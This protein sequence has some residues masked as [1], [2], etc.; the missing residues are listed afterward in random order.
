MQRL[1]QMR[2]LPPRGTG[3]LLGR[4][5]ARRFGNPRTYG[6]RLARHPGVQMLQTRKLNVKTL[7]D[8]MAFS[9]SPFVVAVPSGI[10]TGIRVHDNA[11][12]LDFDWDIGVGWRPSEPEIAVGI[13]TLYIAFYT[14]NEGDGGEL[15]LQ[16][17]AN[18]ET[19]A[20]KTAFAG[21]GVGIGLESGTIPMPDRVYD[22]W[23]AVAP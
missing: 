18:G 16:M 17:R 9:I 13:D 2:R 20:Q 11:R 8:A 14:V 10:I 15:T 21:A 19:I 4:A 12:N 6:Q 23:I 7:S 1:T 22:I 5:G 3:L